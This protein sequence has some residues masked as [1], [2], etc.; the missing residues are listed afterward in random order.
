MKCFQLGE[1]AEHHAGFRE[2]EG[3]ARPAKNRI[4]LPNRPDTAL[5]HR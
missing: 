1:M 2:S 4:E 5:R 3:A